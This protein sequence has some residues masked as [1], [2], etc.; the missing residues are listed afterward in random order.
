MLFSATHS[1]KVDDLVEVALRTNPL[2][3]GVLDKNEAG[4]NGDVTACGLEQV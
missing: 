1:S 3:I 2:K 4:N